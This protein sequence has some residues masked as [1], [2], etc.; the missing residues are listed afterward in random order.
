MPTEK[1]EIPWAKSRGKEMLAAMIMIGDV[2]KHTNYERLY[3]SEPE[4]KKYKIHN[5]KS[6]VKNLIA[7]LAKKEDHATFD[8]IAA[9]ND[10]IRFPR[11]QVT[12]RGYPYWDTSEA[13]A[14]LKPDV[15]NGVHETMTMEEFHNSRDAYLA[16]PK[17]IF[18]KHVH[19]EVSSRLQKSY[20]IKKMQKKEKY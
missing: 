14:W 17:D 18:R 2:D 10:A 19:Q 3:D 15:K 4:F 16:F 6:N 20:W 5:F 7:A 9:T 1:K 12:S 13:L 8:H 11:S